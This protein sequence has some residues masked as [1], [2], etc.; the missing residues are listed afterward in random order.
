[1]PE[2]TKRVILDMDLCI[3]CRS[4][5]AACYYGHKDMPIVNVAEIP[6]GTVPVICRQCREPACV[7]ACP[8]EAMHRN[9]AGVVRR[10]LFR[11]TGCGS[12]VLACPFGVI[13]EE[14]SKKQVAKCDLCEDWASAGRPT[15]C[16]ATCTT[17]ALRFA[18]P[19]ELSEEGLL[20]LGGRAVGR[21]PMKRRV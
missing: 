10:A 2:V 5:A 8:N 19:P 18:E 15:R 4:C 1:M 16:V 3:G 7:E 9:E 14:M 6:E 12:C 17:G 20:V 13:T 11:C 21:S